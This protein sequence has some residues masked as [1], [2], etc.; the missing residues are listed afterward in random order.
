VNSSFGSFDPAAEQTCE[1]LI[2]L[3]LETDEHNVEAL[4]TLA[5]VRLSQQRPDDARQCLERAWNGWKD[6]D[7]GAQFLYAAGLRLAHLRGHRVFPVDYM[8][9]DDPKV[10]PIPV[11]LSLVKLF[12]ELSL[13]NPALI[14]LQG[15]MASDDQEVEAWYL[16]GW[17]FY[18]MAELAHSSPGGKLEGEGL[19]W[20]E[21]AK[22]S[23]DCLETC[24]N[25]GA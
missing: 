12:L 20:E 21:L 13:F 3:A 6:L 10:P 7:L 19:T 1:R 23:R 8:R 4:Q 2:D 17:G 14:T 16:E 22:D 5:S 18:L 24:K 15:I 25:V 9:A 11:R